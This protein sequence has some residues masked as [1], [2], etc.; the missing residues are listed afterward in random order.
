MARTTG[1]VGSIS[2]RLVKKGLKP[3]NTFREHYAPGQARELS[4]SQWLGTGEGVLYSGQIY[5]KTPEWLNLLETYTSDLPVNLSASGAG[6]VLFI[7]VKSRWFALTF[8]YA[9]I[10]LED[11]AFVHQ[12]GLKVAL[13][14]V[15]RGSLLTLD[16][17]T[18]DAVTFQKRVQA[19]D[20]SDISEFGIDTV[21]DLARVAGGK[22][23]DRTF[24][25]FVAGKDML[26]LVD[27]LGPNEFYDKCEAILLM[28]NSKAYQKDYEWFDNVKIVDSTITL[29]ELD[30]S[31]FNEIQRIRGAATDSTLHMSPPEILDYVEG[32][33]LHFNGFGSRRTEF[34]KLSIVEY[35]QEL[36]RLNCTHSIEE[37]KQLHRI[38]STTQ[39]N[40]TFDT[41][42]KTY[43]CFNWETSLTSDGKKQTHYVIFSGKWYTISKLFKDKVESH[44][45]RITPHSIIG[46]T[47]CRN[48]EQLIAHIEKT[49]PD[50][51]KLDRSKLNPKGVNN[52]SL[53]PCD[54]YSRHKYFIH[55]K[56][57]GSSGP[58]SHLWSQ[59]VVSAESFVSDL[60]FR[61]KL[62]AE[63]KKK[64]GGAGFI[65]TLPDNR[66]K[67]I[68]RSDY[69]VVYGIMRTRYAN[70]SIS[71]PFF[72]KVSL[73]A[74]CDRLRALGVNIGLELIEKLPPI[75]PSLTPQANNSL[76]TLSPAAITISLTP[77]LPPP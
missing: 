60:E 71:I 73:I 7:K 61:K 63:L 32:N 76:H 10:V 24:G 41:S 68:V 31:L 14:A 11:E 39:N 59:G 13:N 64:P 66:T 67:N 18:P 72:S 6:A 33:A 75:T 3:E 70:G 9:H 37:I 21:R 53:E 44:F 45:A 47:T 62:R 40:T 30:D 42:W 12:F 5:N 43:D 56:D 36:E 48:E 46:S 74:A 55:L 1:N 65:S 17:A 35:A 25:K 19:S 26:H 58:I 29:K 51:I 4:S 34:T 49:R 28:Y 20:F 38:T 54:F 15:P 57:G 23:S 27:S 50:L 8:G 69:T 52:A 77:P 22:P 16:T 2:V